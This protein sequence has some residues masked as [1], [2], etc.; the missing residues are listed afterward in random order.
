MREGLS[1]LLWLSPPPDFADTKPRHQR[2]GDMGRYGEIRGDTRHQRGGGGVEGGA[3]SGGA[4]RG[5]ASAPP[6]RVGR[7]AVEAVVPV[8]TGAAV[9]R[10]RSRPGGS[11]RDEAA[12]RLA[13]A[14]EGV[15]KGDSAEAALAAAGEG[16]RAGG[17]GDEEGGAAEPD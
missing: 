7:E 1:L 13:H 3:L 15:G 9:K 2:G 10:R 8:S 5:A 16:D 14:G 12:A 6:R 17:G 11:R 4:Q